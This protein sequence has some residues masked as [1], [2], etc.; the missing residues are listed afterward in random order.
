MHANHVRKLH[1]ATFIRIFGNNF[2][3]RQTSCKFYFHLRI[4]TS[5]HKIP[6]PIIN[7]TKYHAF[8]TRLRQ[9]KLDWWLFKNARDD[10]QKQ[11]TKCSQPRLLPISQ[12]K[13]A[14]QIF[15][16]LPINHQLNT[17]F[18][19]KYEVGAGHQG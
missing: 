16:F 6:L 2:R 10:Q 19:C 15:R 9:K 1:S 13:R 14:H 17:Q 11:E 12:C 3:P 5:K 8:I 18:H 4:S 7:Q